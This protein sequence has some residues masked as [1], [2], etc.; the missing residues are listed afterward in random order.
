MKLRLKEWS[1][2]TPPRWDPASDLG[3]PSLLRYTS[4]YYPPTWFDLS[5]PTPTSMR[6]VDAMCQP[7]ITQL[8]RR[9]AAEAASQE[10]TTA[11]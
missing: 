2:W 1:Q 3:N 7:E 5:W 11:S 8:Y 9:K 6:S 10:E 4:S